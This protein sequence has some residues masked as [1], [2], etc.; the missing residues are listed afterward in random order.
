MKCT[1]CLTY[2][3]NLSCPYCYMP[4]GSL[5]M[6][7]SVAMRTVDYLFSRPHRGEGIDIGL[8]GGEPLLAFGMVRLL[9]ELIENH[10]RFSSDVR[11]SIVT[12]GTVVSERI[13][14]Y[15]KEHNIAL[16]VSCDGPPEIQDRFRPMK[17]G[18]PSSRLV[19]DTI[20]R[21][22]AVLPTVLVNSVYGPAT[23]EDLPATVDYVASLGVKNIYLSPDYRAD[24]TSEDARKLPAAYKA[25]ADRYVAS[26]LAGEH[27]FISLIE[28][29]IAALFNGGYRPQ[30]RCRMGREEFAVAPDG[31]LYPCERLMGNVAHCIGH[32]DDVSSFAP[33]FCTVKPL[34]S[35]CRDCGVSEYCMHWCGCSNFFSTGSYDRVGA[36]TCASEK[37]AIAAAVAAHE[38][39]SE[40]LGARYLM[41]LVNQPC[42]TRTGATNALRA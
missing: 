20:R 7:E 3:C 35:P 32:I 39:L 15:A 24:W 14:Q 17:S 38:T 1:I 16:C 6:S 13:L 28:A 31:S 23:I 10:P 4:K 25:V 37:E 19:T 5:S 12:N 40:R 34:S 42:A 41:Q 22:V 29:K 2:Q 30:D 33:S 18:H 11:I 21:A 26:H 36:F 8:F 9:T 27:T